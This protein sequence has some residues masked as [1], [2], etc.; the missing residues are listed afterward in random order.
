M[1]FSDY[2]TKAGAK[3]NI[4]PLVTLTDDT[5]L[6]AVIVFSKWG[7]FYR[8]TYTISRSFPHTIMDVKDENLVPYD[9]G[10]AF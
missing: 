9:C 3:R 4:E 8:Y 1:N 10:I 2:Q 7:G 5:A 6:V